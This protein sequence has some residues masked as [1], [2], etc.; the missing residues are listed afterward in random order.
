MALAFWSLCHDDIHIYT[1]KMIIYCIFY[2]RFKTLQWKCAEC[3]H[4]NNFL[5]GESAPL[6]AAASPSGPSGIKLLQEAHLEISTRGYDVEN[7]PKI[8]PLSYYIM[9]LET[10]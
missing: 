9:Q 10:L 5:C 6:R 2:V 3:I 4:L 8:G 1:H 7:L